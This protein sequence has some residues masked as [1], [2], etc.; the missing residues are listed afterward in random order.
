ML[1]LMHKKGDTLCESVS[2]TYLLCFSFIVSS[3]HLS[4]SYGINRFL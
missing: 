1:T 4:V 3:D 2:G